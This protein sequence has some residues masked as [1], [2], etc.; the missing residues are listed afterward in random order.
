MTENFREKNAARYISLSRGWLRKRRRLR[1]EPAFI[2][3]GKL[4]VYRKADLDAF[5]ERHLQRPEARR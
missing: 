4:I 2:R 5:L 3:V 1:L